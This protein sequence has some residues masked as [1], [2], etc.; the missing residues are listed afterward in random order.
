MTYNV[1][2]LP[3]PRI[4]GRLSLRSSRFRTGTLGESFTLLFRK[5]GETNTGV[6]RG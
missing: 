1:G 5:V 4:Y 2:R 3:M 6:Y